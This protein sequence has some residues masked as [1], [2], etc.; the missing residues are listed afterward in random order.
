MEGMWVAYN[1]PKPITFQPTEDLKISFYMAPRQ[2]SGM[3]QEVMSTEMTVDVE[4][5]K[6][7]LFSDFMEILRKVRNFLCL[8]FDRMVSF[9]SVTGHLQEPNDS[10]SPSN[11]VRVYSK[12]DPYDLEEQSFGL[13]QFLM[14]YEDLADNIED[15]LKRW[16]DGYGEY[17]PTFNLYFTVAANRYMHLE[18]RFLF[19]VHGI[20]SLHRR[21]SPTPTTFMPPEEFDEL[22]ATILKVTPAPRRDWLR[23]KMQFVNEPSLGGRLRQMIAPFNELFGE[24]SARKSFINKVVTTRNYLTHYDNS[25]REEAVTDSRELLQLSRNLEGLLQ[26]RLLKLLGIDEALLKKIVSQYPPLQEKLKIT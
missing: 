13:G 23:G 1:P 12:L 14:R 7:L 26:L 21:S 8:A 19:L 10:A 20:E 9:T 24:R 15:C 22:L 18:G 4:S 11:F 25:R 5:S 16:I 17:E 2:T 6:M 3:F